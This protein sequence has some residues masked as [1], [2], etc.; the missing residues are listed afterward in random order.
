MHRGAFRDFHPIPSTFAFE[1]LSLYIERNLSQSVTV[2]GKVADLGKARYSQVE[3]V[4]SRYSAE[5]TL[6]V[7]YF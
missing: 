1:H 4:T 2:Y 6:Y 5:E 7:L 3:P